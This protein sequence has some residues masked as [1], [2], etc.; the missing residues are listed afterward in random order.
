MAT[1]S[2]ERLLVQATPAS[3]D[4]AAFAVGLAETLSPIAPDAVEQVAQRVRVPESTE[5]LSQALAELILDAIGHWPARRRLVIDDYHLVQDSRA[6]DSFM[7]WVLTLSKLRIV[8]TARR[9]PAWVTARRRLH[10]QVV[11]ITRD[12]LSMSDEEVRA[13][14]ADT[15]TATTDELLRNAEGWPVLIGLAASSTQ[16][17]APAHHVADDL[18]EYFADEIL[19]REQPSVQQTLVRLSVLPNLDSDAISG[20]T[21]ATTPEA[22]IHHLANEGLVREVGP[23]Q[24]AFHPL[25]REFLRSR[26][27]ADEPAETRVVRRALT[28][29]TRD[30]RWDDAFAVAL[31]SNQLSKAAAIVG[32]AAPKLMRQGRLE[33]I[34]KWL[35]QCGP[36]ALSDPD[37]QL[38]VAE[39]HVRRARFR[40][41][42]AVAKLVRS[43][44]VGNVSR[45]G[46]IAAQA[47]YWLE[48]ENEAF[49]LYQEALAKATTRTDTLRALWGCYL[50]SYESEHGDPLAFLE[51]LEEAAGQDVNYRLRSAVGRVTLTHR[52][53]SFSNCWPI[54]EPL[55]PYV[56]WSDDP[57][58]HTSFL[59]LCGFVNIAQA[60]YDVALKFASDGF[61]LSKA[62]G[63]RFALPTFASIT[64]D[65]ELGRRSPRA[66]QRALGMLKQLATTG[67]YPLTRFFLHKSELRWE[68]FTNRSPSNPVSANALDDLEGELQA[69][70]RALYA[71]VYAVSGNSKQSKAEALAASDLGRTAEVTQVIALSEAVSALAQTSHDASRIVANALRSVR[72]VEYPDALILAYRSYLPLLREA[73][74]N[75]EHADYV[76]DAVSRAND[77]RLAARLGLTKAGGAT[78]KLKEVLTPRELEVAQLMAL[79][80]TNREIADQLVI[81]SSTAKVHAHNVVKKLG[82]KNRLDAIARYAASSRDEELTDS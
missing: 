73:V 69:E 48:R 78:P 53:G 80:R 2:R 71:L 82:A 70:I 58:A 62:L 11:E 56:G 34:E 43:H 9:A 44:G 22:L 76:W 10:Q 24:Y 51:Q 25:V 28:K 77:H 63:L 75:G 37:A 46:S 61:T 55:I 79:G 1:G 38:A 5:D 32:Q 41:A 66:A 35:A 3:A 8:V 59:A 21:G 49:D 13:V 23:R 36:A 15:P 4:V 7:D 64:F 20:L 12:D 65:A 60:R 72:E 40:P 31:E 14:L 6:V 54:L 68:L 16:T 74:N 19:R 57:D 27:R 50:T 29:L 26:L 30:E 18:F 47:A 33:T 42:E 45:A 67:D 17:H 39:L 52:S 81:A